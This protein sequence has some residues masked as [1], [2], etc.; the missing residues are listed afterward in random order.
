MTGYRD[1]SYS[2][3]ALALLEKDICYLANM[4]SGGWGMD[5][6]DVAQ[7]LRIHLWRKL[8]KYHPGKAGLR[9]WAQQVMRMRLIDV[10]RKNLKKIPY[11]DDEGNR[12]YTFEGA[13]V[14]DVLDAADR[15]YYEDLGDKELSEDYEWVL[16]ETVTVTF[17]KIVY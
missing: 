5:F 12:K 6:D 3:R 1:D 17:Q 11:F 15:E 8:D 9:A 2:E 10:R 4:Y 16:E 7:E 13:E 14:R